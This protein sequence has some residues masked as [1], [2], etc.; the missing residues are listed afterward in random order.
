MLRALPLFASC[1]S[2]HV[3]IFAYVEHSVLRIK[4]PRGGSSAGPLVLARGVGLDSVK[5]ERVVLIHA[6]DVSVCEYG[7]HARDYEFFCCL[8]G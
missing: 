1:D 7:F 2:V 6:R 3:V 8:C 5:F 4:S